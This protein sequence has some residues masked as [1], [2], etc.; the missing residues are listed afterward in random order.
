LL[1]FEK[2]S[3][4]SHFL[5]TILGFAPHVNYLWNWLAIK[6]SLLPTETLLMFKKQ[7]SQSHF[8]ST[9]LGFAPHV[10]YLW[11]WLAIKRG[12]LP[13]ETL[14][15]FEKQSSQSHFLSTICN[16][17]FYAL[18]VPCMCRGFEKLFETWSETG[19]SVG[20]ATDYGLEGPVLNPGGDEIFRPS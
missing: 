6:R 5:S 17:H 11:N 16:T 12:L 10:N 19:S 18:C 13:T 20:L 14:L 7:S 3:S 15:M 9:I 4:Q 8:L 1:M 2:Q